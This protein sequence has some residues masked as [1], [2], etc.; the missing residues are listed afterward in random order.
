MVV[1]GTGASFFLILTVLLYFFA[2]FL[3]WVCDKQTGAQ[4]SVYHPLCMKG[5]KSLDR[6][7]TFRTLSSQVNEAISGTITRQRLNSN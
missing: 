5:K 3:L 4:G 7:V 1:S 2:L 6:I